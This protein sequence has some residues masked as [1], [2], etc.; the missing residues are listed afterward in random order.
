[1]KLI[2]KVCPLKMSALNATYYNKNG[3]Q[4]INIEVT[5]YLN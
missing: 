4:L 1:M 3:A 5:R 2:E